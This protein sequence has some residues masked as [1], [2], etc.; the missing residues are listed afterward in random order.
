[1]FRGRS[2]N[3]RR[4]H[5]RRDRGVGRRGSGRFRQVDRRPR[6]LWSGSW[7]A[8]RPRRAG[9]WAMPARSSPAARAGASDKIE[10]LKSAGYIRVSDSPASLG[11]T[12]V[13][14]V[15]TIGSMKGGFRPTRG[16]GAGADPA[17]IEERNKTCNAIE[18][19]FLF[20]GPNAE[21]YLADLYATA[22]VT[23]PG[24]S[25]DPSWHAMFFAETA[26]PT[27]APCSTRCRARA[28]AVATATTNG[29]SGVADPKRPMK[30]SR[31]GRGRLRQCRRGRVR[32][33]SRRCAASAST[34]SGA[35]CQARFRSV[36]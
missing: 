18:L 21:F 7:R 23:D 1:M 12:H 36:P 3:R 5:D 35:R 32:A 2:G 15:A 34:T 4:Y 13:G 25:V 14:G 16:A 9:A 27:A 26:R 6:S 30:Q 10:A 19:S 29:A 24:L 33:A 28:G 20:N 22:T 11:S 8:F 17:A 31:Q